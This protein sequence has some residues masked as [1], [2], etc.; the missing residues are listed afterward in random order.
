MFSFSSCKKNNDNNDDNSGTNG[1]SD[2]AIQ[3]FPTGTNCYITVYD[4]SDPITNLNEMYSSIQNWGGIARGK[5]TSSPIK[6]NE[7]L[8]GVYFLTINPG[9][10]PYLYY[11][12]VLFT[13]GETTIDWDTPTF[14]WDGS[15][16]WWH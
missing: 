10:Y 3:N 8:D 11:S 2:I 5:G 9:K 13:Q 12:Q 14:T 4:C 6:I 7:T 15:D 16:D 1:S